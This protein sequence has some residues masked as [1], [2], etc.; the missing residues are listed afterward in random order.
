MKLKRFFNT[1]LFALPL[2]LTVSCTDDVISMTPE[3]DFSDVP[4]AIKNGYSVS[5]TVTLPSLG[6]EGTSLNDVLTGN[7]YLREIENYVDL[8][9]LRVLFFTCTNSTDD[10]GKYDYF[11]F[12]SRS[13]WVSEI[14]DALTTQASWQ[15]TS[16]V[17]TY[18]NTEVYDWEAIRNALTTKPFKIALLVNRPD[19]VSFGNF[20]D[21]FTG[22]ITFDT[23]RGPNW[24]PENTW[25]EGDENNRANWKTINDLHHCQW[26]PIYS[27]KNQGVH[28]YDFIMEK[29]YANVEF[30]K[31]EIPLEIQSGVGSYNMMGALSY[32][33]VKEDSLDKSGNQ[34]WEVNKNT[35]IKETV[36]RKEP[37]D[38][39]KD[40]NFYFHPTKEQGIPMYGVQKFSA[41]PDWKPGTPYNVSIQETGSTG[42]YT[43]KNV[44]LL[45]S[46]VKLELKIPKQMTKAN[47]EVVDIDVKYP[48]LY[49]SN[50]MARCEPLDVAT[51]TELLW[52]TDIMN[53]EDPKTRCEWENIYRYGPIVT[54]DENEGKKYED[55]QRAAGVNT[56][57]SRY[58]WFYGAWKDWWH[59]NYNVPDNE[60]KAGAT[61][62]GY[63]KSQYENDPNIPYPR[64]YNPV[65]QRNGIA[66]IEYCKIEDPDY[67]YFVVY[68]GERN[69]ND[70]SSVNEFKTDNA[71]VAFFKFQ[72][73]KV[74][75]IVGITDYA[76]NG[77]IK[78]WSSGFKDL[79]EYKK[80]MCGYQGP[81]NW[82]WPLLRNHVYTFTVTKIGDLTDN[83]GID[84]QVVSTENRE[85]PA[86]R[87]D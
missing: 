39:T 66:G 21:K 14:S 63:N 49:Y 11:L 28:V 10:S 48:Y 57:H 52:K 12:E 58:A 8:E 23:D 60:K 54:K 18:G 76:K 56:F 30:K 61:V 7:A 86:I 59:Y 25:K 32:W 55:G 67:H 38:P 85:A 64:I 2:A 62:Y 78:N 35:G 6:A 84:V 3:D 46:L 15:V 43:R 51:P 73:E 1:I 72:I 42:S 13:R 77:Y 53:N 71:E 83:A 40:K 5:F 41:I 65:I 79:A 34:I 31:Y 29:P 81:D 26:D 4:E 74:W 69:I 87:Y 44:H 20:D 19:K 80:A 16:P 68:T 37:L 27:S 50:V 17:F 75:Y 82:N 47:G 33:T 36:K 24:G 9:K 45:R 22:I 70:P